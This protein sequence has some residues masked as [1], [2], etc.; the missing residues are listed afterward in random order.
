MIYMCPKRRGFTLIELL[1]VIAIIAILA[2]ILFPV[3]TNAKQASARSR[4]LSNLKQLGFALQMYVQNSNGCYPRIDVYQAS[5]VGDD[6]IGNNKP[7]G[8]YYLGNLMG[9]DLSHNSKKKKYIAYYSIMTQ[10]APFTRSKGVWVCP[11]DGGASTMPT[12][13]RGIDQYNYTKRMVSYQYKFA[14]GVQA[15]YEHS[16]TWKENQF[17]YPT[18]TIVFNECYPWHAQYGN[19]YAALADEKAIIQVCLMD[20]HAICAPQGKLY[21]RRIID[22]KEYTMFD[23]NWFY[24][25]GPRDF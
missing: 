5:L 25:P 11:T 20:G 15:I 19:G 3:F 22:G 6:V 17:P 13:D 16:K 14:I 7:T 24:L 21:H 12:G 2:A 1:V 10:L 18:R 23:Y 9:E 4:C 8:D